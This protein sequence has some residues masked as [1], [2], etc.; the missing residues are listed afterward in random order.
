MKRLFTFLLIYLFL[1]A[2]GFSQR[3]IDALFNKYGNSDGFVTLTINGDLLNLFKS[4][5]SCS[6]EGHW[7]GKVTEIRLLVQDDENMEV[8]NFYEMA[9]QGLNKKD[10]EEYMSIRES[11]Q[12]IKMFVRSEGNVVKE[13]LL[14][15]GGEDNFII[16]VKGKMT[17]EEAEEFS[18]EAKRNHCKDL[19]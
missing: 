6:N 17:F 1:S 19:L 2:C 3:S 9:I 14:I 16:Q 13:F 4:D 8:Q 18:S 10:Y 5:K 15:A 12:D 11:D 7:P